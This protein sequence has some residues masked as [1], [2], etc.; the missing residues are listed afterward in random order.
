L[1]N[2]DLTF[3]DESTRGVC[4]RLTAPK[5]VDITDLQR[6]FQLHFI[7]LMGILFTKTGEGEGVCQCHGR[8][9]RVRI[10]Y[11]LKYAA[12]ELLLSLSTDQKLSMPS[13]EICSSGWQSF[14]R[15]WMRGLPSKT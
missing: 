15:N 11:C 5:A 1:E 6:R 10:K 4:H 14:S 3:S 13:P 2:D 12:V 9:D 7:C 8:K